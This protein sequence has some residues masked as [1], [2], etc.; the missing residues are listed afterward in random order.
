MAVLSKVTAEQ[1]HLNA[2]DTRTDGNIV[3]TG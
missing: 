3:S 2:M 1:L